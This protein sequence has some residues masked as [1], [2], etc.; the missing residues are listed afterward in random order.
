MTLV[1]FVF[2]GL[3]CSLFE[4]VRYHLQSAQS[5]PAKPVH[6]IRHAEVKDDTIIVGY[7]IRFLVPLRTKFMDYD[8]T[9]T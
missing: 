5:D 2:F 4:V 3:Y 9:N 8:P 1:R 6:K 7:V